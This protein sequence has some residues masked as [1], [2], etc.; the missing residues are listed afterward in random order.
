M[1]FSSDP[2]LNT[3]QLPISLDV[4]PDE[5]NYQQILVL[6]LRRIANAVNTKESGLFLLQE[7][8]NFQQWFG[9]TPQENRNAYRLTVDLVALNGGNPIGATF[10]KAL[11]TITQPVA[12]KGYKFPLPSAGA[13]LDNTGISYF[14]NDPDIYVRYI[15]S[16]N[17]IILTNNT[18]NTLTWCVFEFN[19]LKN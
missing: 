14:L 5:D 19:Y 18:G 2:A 17:T 15:G 1:T 16:T 12:P 11:S 7:N 13:A 3:N 9:T 6:Y 10:T 8:A 4:N